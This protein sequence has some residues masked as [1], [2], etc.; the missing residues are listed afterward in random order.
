VAAVL[1][2]AAAMPAAQAVRA[3]A[4]M[5][6]SFRIVEACTVRTS[7]ASGQDFDIRC[8]YQTPYRV[9]AGND[10][11]ALRRNE[12]PLDTDAPAA[13]TVWF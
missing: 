8:Q 1:A 11:G 9:Q 5:E 10:T 3:T 4:T 12:R 2:L 13:L 6:V 7:Q